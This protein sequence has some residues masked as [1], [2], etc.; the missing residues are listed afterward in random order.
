MEDLK[1]LKVKN[2]K[3]IT[4]DR[5]TWKDLAEKAK[6]HKILKCQKMKMIPWVREKAFPH[7]F[8]P[9]DSSRHARSLESDENEACGIKTLAGPSHRAV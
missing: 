5:R 6:T 1:E 9:Q 4:K 3:A 8:I 7:P 2:W